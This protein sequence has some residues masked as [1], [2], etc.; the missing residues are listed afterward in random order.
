MYP[1]HLLKTKPQTT[2]HLAQTMSLLNMTSAELKQTIEAELANNPALELLEPRR[3][4]GCGRYL[5]ETKTCPICNQLHDP[6]GSEP[7]VFT[8]SRSDYI[9]TNSGGS[10]HTISPE[11][12]PD[13]NTAPALDLPS[14]VLRQI[15][16]E[17]AEDDRPIAAHILTSLDEDGLLTISPMEIS[18]Y[19][20]ISIER[21]KNVLKLIQRSEPVGVGSSSPQ[22]AL[23]VQLDVLSKTQDVPPHVENAIRE[24]IDLLSRHHFTKLGQLLG[25][26]AQEAEEISR[27]I[28]TN[29]NPYPARSHWGSVRQGSEPTPNVYHNPDILISHLNNNPN[30]PLV[31]EILF[32]VRSPL[33]LNPVFQKEIKNADGEKIEKWQRDLEKA[34]L[35][36]KCLRQ[37]NNTMRQLLSILTQYQRE[38]ITQ[39]D[40]FLKPITRSSM[41]EILDVHESTVSRAVS[42]KTARLPNGRIIPLGKFF[43]RSLPIRALIRE[44]VDDEVKA[45]TDSQIAGLLEDKGYNVA[46]R[47]VAKYRSMEGILSARTRQSMARQS[48]THQSVSKV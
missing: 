45:L 5:V 2:A 37:R 40:R 44:I 15:A 47:T 8:S 33:R 26:S 19:R 1:I 16:P 18:R 3:C 11:D 38:F 17:L 30:G 48:M 12:L 25:I 23:L 31:I 43:D 28:S 4:K 6:N 29:L 36:I 9:F 21:V 42:G 20:H 35:L 27:Y 41:A 10:T 46:R 7:I 22:E 32:P 14:F 13:D 39:G 34:S 24:G